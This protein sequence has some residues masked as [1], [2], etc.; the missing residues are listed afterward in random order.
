MELFKNNGD[1]KKPEI[2]NYQVNSKGE[3]LKVNDKNFKETKKEKIISRKKK[4]DDMISNLYIVDIKEEI[5]NF[6]KDPK[7]FKNYIDTLSQKNNKETIKH[8]LDTFIEEFELIKNSLEEAKEKLLEYRLDFKNS[9]NIE[10]DEEI[11][12]KLEKDLYLFNFY[13]K[14]TEELLEFSKKEVTKYL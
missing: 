2:S 5:F 4:I 8:Y 6:L 13:I 14:R 7:N 10:E 1:N 12:R 11:K 9:N 3:I